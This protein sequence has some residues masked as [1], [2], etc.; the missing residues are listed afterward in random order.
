MQQDPI[1]VAGRGLLLY[2]YSLFKTGEIH[3]RNNDAWDRPIGKLL[4]ALGELVKRER[5]GITLVVYEGVVMVNS[6]PMWLDKGTGQQAEEMERWLAYKEAGGVVFPQNPTPDDLRTFFFTCARHRAP[7]NTEDPLGNVCAA[8]EAEG[9]KDIRLTQ[10]PIQLEGVGRGVRGVASLWHYAKC[11]AAMNDLLS[12][13]PL[14]NRAVRRIGQELVDA[15][16]AE[17]D[18]L[19]GLMLLGRI[20]SP[21]RRCIDLGILMASVGRGL[22]LSAVQC[23]D[24][25]EAGLCSQAGRIY[26]NPNPHLFTDP[27][28]FG[29]NPLRA[30]LDAQ[31]VTPGVAQRVAAAVSQSL[32]ADGRGP[33]YLAG[34]PAPGLTTQLLLIARQYLGSV[35]GHD[36]APRRSPLQTVM[37]LLE[38]PP[39]GVEP[40]LVQCFVAT[41][42]ILPV[43]TLVE[44]G[45]SD[46]A[47]VSDVEHLRGRSV[48][49]KRP[50]PLAGPRTVWIER[51][52]T[53]KGNVVPERKARVAL[54]S[55]DDKGNQWIAARTLDGTEHRDLIV[56][57]LIR[58]PATVIAQMGLR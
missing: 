55:A 45:N 16:A 17:Q 53:S 40:D 19:C 38:R 21:E 33:P 1:Q 13:A 41:V 57:A 52:R 50:A 28:A 36:D 22:G 15:C 35:L 24:L 27:E 12:K 34:A 58:R 25:T 39:V 26:G 51:L 54:G 47:V 5:Q 43:G 31:H 23:V 14:D 18:L 10:R 7:P 6:H 29:L 30:L 48:Y 4:E 42:G 32:G 56:R 49:R 37:A 11:T 44:L 9:V 46:I 3:D 8:V 20:D 2:T